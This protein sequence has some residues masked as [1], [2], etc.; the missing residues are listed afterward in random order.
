MDEELRRKA[1]KYVVSFRKY[2]ASIQNEE[3]ADQ[4]NCDIEACI[5]RI[6]EWYRDKTDGWDWHEYSEGTW[7]LCASSCLV[8]I[9][10][11]QEW[12]LEETFFEKIIFTLGM[13]GDE[14]GYDYKGLRTIREY[15]KYLPYEYLA[16]IL[17]RAERLDHGAFRS[18]FRYTVLHALIESSSLSFMEDQSDEVTVNEAFMEQ[19]KFRYYDCYL[20]ADLILKKLRSYLASN[21]PE[22]HYISI[23]ELNK[24][25]KSSISRTQ[26]LFAVKKGE[27]YVLLK[28]DRSRNGLYYSLTYNPDVDAMDYIYDL[29]INLENNEIIIHLDTANVNSPAASIPPITL[30]FDVGNWDTLQFENDDAESL[31]NNLFR[32]LRLSGEERE[33]FELICYVGKNLHG[34]SDRIVYFRNDFEAELDGSQIIL[35]KCEREHRMP[36]N[37]FGKTINNICAVVGQN[38]S[39]KTSVFYSILHDSAFGF[40][41]NEADKEM[42]FLLYQVG[43]NY[44]YSISGELELCNQTGTEINKMQNSPSGVSICY[45]SNTFDLFSLDLSSANQPQKTKEG[46]Y[47][48]LSAVYQIQRLRQIQKQMQQPDPDKGQEKPE[49]QEDTV[50][51]KTDYLQRYQ[52]QELQRFRNLVLFIENYDEQEKLSTELLKLK[53]IDTTSDNFPR[54][55]SGEY[56]RWSL[57]AK[58]LSVFYRGP[59]TEENLLPEIPKRDNYIILFDEAELYMHPE[60]QRTLICDIISFLETINKNQQF[61]TNITLLFSSNSPFLMSDLPSEKIQLFSL[62]AADQKT[63]GQNI[64]SILKDRFFMPNGPIGAFAARCINKALKVDEKSTDDEK[65][66]L[67]YLA[68]IVGDELIAYELKRRVEK[69]ADRMEGTEQDVSNSV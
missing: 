68:G 34:L 53:P 17:N 1:R 16:E 6:L 46:C 8:S 33:R 18:S 50:Q 49:P 32:W 5:Q 47:A 20:L 60:W 37:F 43:E 45:L 24:L 38:G 30:P 22:Y 12:N 2:I 57:F 39:G 15:A 64:Y 28:L 26:F 51:N 63:F 35:R 40:E 25:N 54:L 61:F 41:S 65:E 44:Y 19:V 9:E 11:L 31:T 69:N 29:G 52:E 62:D 21:Y 13:A 55:S 36:E 14:L 23:D 48:D 59:E 66:Y 27:D 67:K 58:L 7:I 10:Q 42:S 3:N 4:D 56:A